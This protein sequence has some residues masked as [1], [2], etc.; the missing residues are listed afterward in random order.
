MAMPG[1]PCLLLLLYLTC[2]AALEVSAPTSNRV[3]L[4]SSAILPCTFTVKDPSINFNFLAIMWYFQGNQIVNFDTKGVNQDFR[5]FINKQEISK[6]IADLHIINVTISD[7]GT[8]KC[9]IIYSPNT[10]FKEVEVSVYALPS[11]THLEKV[12]GENEENRYLCSVSGFYPRNIT[13]EM[14][15]DGNVIEG[16]V[17]SNPHENTDGTFSVDSTVIIHP[18]KKPK[19]LSCRVRHA[20]L[21][22]DLQQKFLLVYNEQ[23]NSNVGLVVGIVIAAIV[24]MLLIIAAVLY[25]KRKSGLPETVVG[26]IQSATWINGEKTTLYCTASTCA[27]DVL[28]TWAIRN[29]DGTTCEVSETPEGDKEEEQ[30]LMSRE[31]NVTT[32]KIPNQRR[33]G[34]YDI[35]TKLTFIPSVSRH[36]GANVSCKIVA[37]K[38]EEEKTYQFKSIHAK[39]TFLDPIQFSLCN[40]D[41]VQLSATIPRFYPQ[42]LQISWVCTS[43]KYQEKIPS[44]EH[45]MNNTD[46]TYNV[47]SQCTVP[48]ALFT[49]PTSKVI[50]TWKHE[51]IDVSQSRELSVRDLPW[52][53]QIPD[54]P[55]KSIHQGDE[56]HLRCTVSNYFPDALTVKWFEKKKGSPDVVDISQSDKY[57]IPKITSNRM[58]NKTFTSTAVLALRKSQLLEKDVEFICR[59]EHPGLETPIQSSTLQPWNTDVQDFIVNNIQ[60]PQT[61]QNGEK[62]TVYCAAIYCTGD[63][64]VVWTVR[65]KDGNVREISE[66]PTGE[67]MR[68]D[69]TR[70]S[71]YLALRE[72]ID[73]SD[74]EGL[75]DLTSSLSFLTS[76]SKH[77]KITISCKI[78][79]GGRSK[80][81]TFQP[82]HLFAKPK[83]VNPIRL[84]LT[85]LGE[86]LCSLDIEGFYPKDI[87]IKWNNAET[88]ISHKVIKS[89]DSTYSVHSEYKIPGGF[90]KDSKSSATVS[91]KH[92]SAED[93]ESRHVSVLDKEFPWK[94][95]LQDILVPNLLIG[96]TAT[97]RCEV[98]NVFPDAL[99]VRWLKK[100]RHSQE[101]FPLGPSD[102]YSISEIK[103]EKQKDN[104]FTYK[105]CIKFKP[106]IASEEGAE[107]ICR[108]EHPSL[109]EPAEKNTGALCIKDDHQIFIVGNINGPNRWTHG[110]KVTLYCSVS[111]CPEDVN[112]RWTVTESDG[113]QVI[114]SST[115]EKPLGEQEVLSSAGYFLSTEM[116]KSDKEGLLNI[117]SLMSLIPSVS[118]HVGTEFTCT[119][120]SN[121]KTKIKSFKPKSICAKPVLDDIKTTMCDSGDVLCSLSLHNV[122]PKH[123]TLTWTTGKGQLPSK[124]TEDWKENSDKTYTVCSQ[125]TVPGRL[126]MDPS[127]EVSVTWKHKSLD[128][129]ETRV[130]SGRDLGRGWRPEIQAVPVPHILVRKRTTF[131][132]NISRYFPDALT[133]SWYKKKNGDQT[134]NPLSAG[135]KCDVSV[136]QSHRQL[137]GTYSCTASLVLTPSLGD[138]GSEFLCRVG[139]PSLETPI[140]RSSGELQVMAKPNKRKSVKLSLGKE[141]VKYSLLL[142]NFFPRDIHIQWCYGSGGQLTETC[143]S[144]EKY[145][146]NM[147]K[148]FSVTSEC[149][150]P[151]THI[152]IPDFRVRVTWSHESMD[153][154]ECSE[155]SVTDTDYP[156]RPQMEISVPHLRMNEE[157]SLQCTISKYF[158]SAVTVTWLRK[159]PVSGDTRCVS[160][161][162]LYIVSTEHLGRQPD[163]TYSCRSRLTFLPTLD[164]EHGA[165]FICRVQ[166]PSLVQPL[167]RSTGPLHVTDTHQDNPPQ[168]H[169]HNDT[170][171]EIPP[172]HYVTTD[173]NRDVNTHQENPPQHHGH[174]D[175]H[176]EIPPSH[177]VAEI[178][179]SHYVAADGKRDLSQEKIV[180]NNVSHTDVEMDTPYEN[181][182]H[183]HG[184]SAPNYPLSPHAAAAHSGQQ[185]EDMETE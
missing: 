112:V 54:G 51:S 176:Y 114:V 9:I 40:Q 146:T 121:G 109:Q 61:W 27:Q 174:N 147:D 7:A 85:D 160:P 8:Y 143:A 83:V 95:E 94:P 180:L 67:D 166:H 80:E 140:E 169:G 98:S 37:D 76:I 118:R 148:T 164:E 65:E 132:Y 128:K 152:N 139:H 116:D 134:F 11:I 86:V 184:H 39:P 31:Y 101:Y 104:T 111:N 144:K 130:L 30:P 99:T 12:S 161:S 14:L 173:G 81:K 158:P 138:R 125:C 96:S 151:E 113:K 107:F 42:A 15:M 45:I 78:V 90:F 133:V 56:V 69:D 3:Q 21:T 117:T 154:P 63:S 66:S 17:M 171:Y 181:P 52:K 73:E 162:G 135:D 141:E 25:K 149:G 6:G 24:V 110:D 72:R 75:L 175:T 22:P 64:R 50:V 93:W 23:N 19:D 60:G 88:L 32:E 106:S 150:L 127:A 185:D 103:P 4:R 119:V 129:P 48:G 89:T 82:K 34:L 18:G 115:G 108:V 122:Y 1:S 123:L 137:D 97:L 33:K 57:T 58:D 153:E 44:Q 10:K 183:H 165:E 43:A 159:D 182:P 136:T 172:S 74:K 29:K 36:L 41:D 5:R 124:P 70:S 170:H 178:P 87:Q 2:G 46:A 84:S 53:P 35:N 163:N 28:V 120:I 26:N 157:A 102:R 142:E 179:P 91:W 77:K 156:W 20:S 49:D 59:V 13:V 71:G 92:E 126:F 155:L 167:E 68:R 168:H 16:S 105:T 62:V 55:I 47:K 100:E 38:K 177:Y 145:N 79:T 131:Q